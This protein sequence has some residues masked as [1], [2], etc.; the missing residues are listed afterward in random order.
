LE[1]EITAE[2]ETLVVAAYVNMTRLYVLAR[3]DDDGRSGDGR[4]CQGSRS[5]LAT[6]P[7][8]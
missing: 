8:L 7:G 3:A 5:A 6:I 4:R 2:V 1:H